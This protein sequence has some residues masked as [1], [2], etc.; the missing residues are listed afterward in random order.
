MN[1][2]LVCRVA[3]VRWNFVGLN[4]KK[5]NWHYNLLSDLVPLK[6]TSIDNID[7]PNDIGIITY[8]W[9][10]REFCLTRKK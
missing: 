5:R 4:T 9:V 6:L 8:F 1:N 2:I 3:I 7:Y 10:Y